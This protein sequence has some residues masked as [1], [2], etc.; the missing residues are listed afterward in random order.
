MAVCTQVDQAQL[1]CK[2]L[3]SSSSG[4]HTCHEGTWAG[5]LI[6]ARSRSQLGNLWSTRQLLLTFYAGA[7]PIALKPE[8]CQRMFVHVLELPEAGMAL[9]DSTCKHC[10]S[11]SALMLLHGAAFLAFFLPTTGPFGPYTLQKQVLAFVPQLR[12]EQVQNWTGYYSPAAS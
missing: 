12:K 9:F 6:P 10:R 7:C 1:S 3:D 4:R 5:T 2:C 8:V 11:S